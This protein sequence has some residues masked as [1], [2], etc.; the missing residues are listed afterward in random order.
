MK[1]NIVLKGSGFKN[2][3]ISVGDK[4]LTKETRMFSV[5]GRYF[6][7][8]NC[9]ADQQVTFVY[10]PEWVHDV[11]DK[12][13]DIIIVI[14][15]ELFGKLE[16]KAVSKLTKSHNIVN[17]NSQLNLREAYMLAQE[18]TGCVY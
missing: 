18:F 14:E 8:T 2:G 7:T 5:R 10:V 17:E 15:N 1:L 6:V 13:N 3:S 11:C 12:N 4:E 16:F 9:R